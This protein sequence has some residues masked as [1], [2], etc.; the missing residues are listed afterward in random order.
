[1]KK[2]DVGIDARKAKEGAADVEGA[3]DKMVNAA[4]GA[5]GKMDQSGN[6][7]NRNLKE[8]GDQAE[9]SKRKIDFFKGAFIFTAAIAGTVAL[10]ASVQ[11]LI[12]DIDDIG[13][14]AGKANVSTDFFQKLE[15]AASQSGVEVS[16]VNG[17]LKD[18]TIRLGQ[19]AGGS[20][21]MIDAFEKIGIEIRN[22]DGSLKSVE[23]LFP[24]V[25]DGLAGLGS[26]AERAAVGVQLMGESYTQANNLLKD[27]AETFDILGAKAKD[28][29]IIMSEETFKAAA[30]LNDEMDILT[31]IVKV[32]FAGALTT[33]APLLIDTIKFVGRFSSA[34]GTLVDKFKELAGFTDKK[35]FSGFTDQ[36][37]NALTPIKELVKQ[38]KEAKAVIVDKGLKDPALAAQLQVIA[39]MELELARRR[40]VNNEIETATAA[41]QAR[42]DL[43]IRWQNAIAANRMAKEEAAFEEQMANIAARKLAEE[44]LLLI[45]QIGIGTEP[46]PTRTNSEKQDLISQIGIGTEPDQNTG[47][48]VAQDFLTAETDQIANA[49]LTREELLFNSF[50]KQQAILEAAMG[51]NVIT[52]QKGQDLITSINLRAFRVRA[53]MYGQSISTMIGGIGDLVKATS[54][55]N[56]EMTSMAKALARTQIVINTAV[57]IMKAYADLGP[58]AGTFAAI[59]IAAAG[60]AQFINVDNA[61]STP[62][63][64]DLSGSQPSFETRADIQRQNNTSTIINFTVTGVAPQEYI[65]STLVPAMADIINQ[66]DTV[67]FDNNSRQAQ[68]LGGA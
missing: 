43:E 51:A 42:S 35:P 34:V 41:L 68:I 24:Q 54:D 11:G 53:T 3:F 31:R 19:A 58:G 38:I 1:M 23:Q 12:T 36:A 65:E 30:K 55:S 64:T 26:D 8:T 14:A 18:L 9:R 7:I 60:A 6:K 48:Q 4:K 66:N 28:M 39:N 29:G 46:G 50:E 21:P 10:A 13:K 63:A 52:E 17:L 16:T 62:S 45:S 40:E 44:E 47:L 37:E 20:Q 5:S 25:A 61:G 22:A 32:G 15:F 59:G 33:I 57:G 67:L 49:Y 56:G 2:I 27:G